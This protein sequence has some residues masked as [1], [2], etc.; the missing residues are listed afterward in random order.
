MGVITMRI[1]AIIIGAV[2]SMV[3]GL[4]PTG[5]DAQQWHGNVNETPIWGSDPAASRETTVVCESINYQPKTCPADTHGQV[6]LVTRLGGDCGL[7]ES[8]NFDAHAVYVRSGCRGV[9]AVGRAGG[10]L[11]GQGG[12]T[13]DYQRGIFRT[14]CQSL[15]WEPKTCPVNTAGNIRLDHVIA[16]DCRQGNTWTYDKGNIYVRGGCQAA[17]V[18]GPGLGG[19]ANDPGFAPQ[20]SLPPPP[21]RNGFVTCQSQNYQP[22]TCAADTRGRAVISQRLGG[23]CVLGRNWSFDN[24]AIY[25]SQG[26]RAV[27]AVAGQPH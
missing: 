7:G 12:A 19:G 26:C 10:P 4:A 25:V 6:K 14:N 13:P 16:G 3:I 17:F 15:N 27:F 18:S 5:A 9:F 1:R 20:P 2:M 21:V 8:W 24:R 22:A 11:P 23:D